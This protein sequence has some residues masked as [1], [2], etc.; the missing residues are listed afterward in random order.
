M[1]SSLRLQ[2]F[3]SYKDEAFEFD[4]G[5][6][7]IVG[8]NAIGKTNLIEALVFI[9]K[10]YSFRV[11]DIDLIKD[12]EEFLRLEINIKDEQRQVLVNKQQE[13]TIKNFKLND[14]NYKR[15]TKNHIYPIVLFEPTHLNL[16][17]LNKDYRRK[18][19]DDLVSEIEPE[20]PKIISQYNRALIQRNNLLKKG[21]LNNLFPW[22]LRLSQLSGQIIKNRGLLIKE[23]NPRIRKIYQKL[24]DSNQEVS[25]SYISNI[26]LNNYETKFLNYLEKN[27]LDDQRVGFTQKGIHRDDFSAK[28]DDRNS[29]RKA[30][31]GEQRSIILALKIAEK[32][33]LEE[34]Q[35]RDVIFILD[36]VF[37]E[38]DGQRRK[39]LLDEIK[40]NQSFITTTDADM[41]INHLNDNYKIIALV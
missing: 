5:I 39:F 34:Y 19:L 11:K 25:L 2:N 6:N 37:S 33:I 3:R 26:D 16:F 12:N 14:K 15:L 22:N 24:S 38:L 17:V 32:L 31:R 8:P 29:T 30:S 20:H 10:G 21:Q 27:A 13:K 40:N 18:Y 9:L 23:I 7:I 4:N 36:D 41:V 35:K 1:I 28:I